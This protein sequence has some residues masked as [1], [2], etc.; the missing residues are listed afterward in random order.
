MRILAIDPGYDRVGVAVVEGTASLPILLHSECI[1][2]ERNTPAENRL[3]S[4]SAR[5]SKIISKF[6]PEEMAVESLF[7]S[8]NQKTAIGVA[9]ARGCILAEAGKKK[10]PVRSF[11]PNSVKVAVT[12]YGGSK[13]A[14]VTDMVKRLIK[15]RAMIEHDDEYDAIAI[16]IAALAT[17][18]SS[19]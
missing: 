11:N 3:A 18:R 2:T 10:I 9:E 1:V 17:R 13:K 6:K 15:M 4:I 7:F 16:G 12:G 8:V 14:G 19:K 5:I